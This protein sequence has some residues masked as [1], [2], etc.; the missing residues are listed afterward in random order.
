MKRSLI[1]FAAALF[2]FSNVQSA[3]TI[4]STADPKSF[5]VLELVGFDRDNN[6]LGGVRLPQL[7]LEQRDKL[8]YLIENA[9]TDYPYNLRDWARGLM[10]YNVSTRCVETW[11][12]TMW[13]A[14]CI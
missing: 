11:N 9:P 7:T 12:G 13:T 14:S 4:G 10:I 2:S 3:V 5:S 6:L 1:I 8:T